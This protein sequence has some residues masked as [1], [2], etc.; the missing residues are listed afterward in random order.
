VYLRPTGD[1]SL[2]L[3][4]V[5]VDLDGEKDFKIHHLAA[6]PVDVGCKA[7]S[8]KLDLYGNRLSVR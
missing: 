4:V 6:Q 8:A 1:V 3:P 2:T 5:Y 7:V